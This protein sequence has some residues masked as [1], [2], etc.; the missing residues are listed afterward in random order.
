M[1]EL[2]VNATLG[3]TEASTICTG[4]VECTHLALRCTRLALGLTTGSN[5]GGSCKAMPLIDFE[6][7]STIDTPES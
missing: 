2:C 3:G 5:L 7:V 1:T 4:P 6:L